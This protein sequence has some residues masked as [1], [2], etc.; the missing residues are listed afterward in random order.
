MGFADVPSFHISLW[1]D[2]LFEAF[3]QILVVRI[4]N[5]FLPAPLAPSVLI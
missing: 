1:K 2:N 3:Q 5:G 4:F